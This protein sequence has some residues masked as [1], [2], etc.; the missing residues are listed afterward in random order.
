MGLHQIVWAFLA[1]L[2][3]NLNEFLLAMWE[4]DSLAVAR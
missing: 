2:L 3:Q 1:Q 4:D